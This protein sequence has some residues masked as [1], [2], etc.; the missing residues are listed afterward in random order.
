VED[1]MK[2]LSPIILMTLSALMKFSGKHEAANYYAL[3]AIFSVA[4]N[5]LIRLD[6][7]K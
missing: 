6:G 1:M 4:M 7:K 5:T 3:I 2:Y